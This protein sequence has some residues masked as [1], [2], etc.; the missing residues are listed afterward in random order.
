MCEKNINITTLTCYHLGRQTK[1]LSSWLLSNQINQYIQLGFQYF[2][3]SDD[4]FQFGDAD[5]SFCC[6]TEIRNLT[7]VREILFFIMHHDTIFY[8]CARN[9]RAVQCVTRVR[10]RMHR[11]YQFTPLRKSSASII[12]SQEIFYSIYHNIQ[13]LNCFR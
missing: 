9:S 12:N 5:T 13:F 4:R 8:H 11:V 6:D 3:L 10:V 1:K 7:L 2:F